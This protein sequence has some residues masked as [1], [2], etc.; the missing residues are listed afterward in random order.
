MC[1]HLPNMVLHIQLY[2][3]YYYASHLNTST[4]CCCCW[5]CAQHRLLDDIYFPTC[6]LAVIAGFDPTGKYHTLDIQQQ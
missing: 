4:R 5:M 2:R 3:G 6:I 1:T